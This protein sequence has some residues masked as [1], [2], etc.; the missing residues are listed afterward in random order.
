MLPRSIHP[1]GRQVATTIVADRP[2]STTTTS[3][4]SDIARA[5]EAST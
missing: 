4:P 3:A 2:A 1:P 5:R